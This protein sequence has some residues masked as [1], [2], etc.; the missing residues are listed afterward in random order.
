[1]ILVVGASAVI[2]GRYITNEGPETVQY[3]L[4]AAFQQ[5]N[6]E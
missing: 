1:M 4:G 3:T 5:A 6:A 2:S